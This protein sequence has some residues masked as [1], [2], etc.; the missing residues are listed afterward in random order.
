MS[1]V[2]YFIDELDG[3]RPTPQHLR[4]LKAHHEYQARIDRFIGKTDLKSFMRAVPRY[5]PRGK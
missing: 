1:L 3:K 5:H 4:L 2:H